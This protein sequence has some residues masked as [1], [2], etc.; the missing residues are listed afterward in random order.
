M[1]FCRRSV[2]S[3]PKLMPAHSNMAASSA[4]FGIANL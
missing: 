3:S 4:K 2:F 1:D